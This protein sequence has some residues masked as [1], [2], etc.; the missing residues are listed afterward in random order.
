MW[1]AMLGMR[2][3][4][5]EDDHRVA[6]MLGRLLSKEGFVVDRART[7]TDAVRKALRHTY[8]CIVL[9]LMLPEMDGLEVCR[10]VRSA[11]CTS[12]I[13][14]LTA[15]TALADRVA[16]LDEGAD[17][18]LG[19]P[20]APT[21]LLARLR[22][23]LRRVPDDH[24]PVVQLGEFVLDREARTVELGGEV[25]ELRPREVELMWFFMNHPG[26]AFGRAEILSEVWGYDYS[27]NVVDVYVAYLREKIDR[28]FGVDVIQTVRGVGYRFSPPSNVRTV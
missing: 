15:R 21:E 9:D 14:M 10:E 28:R 19:K 23:L 11:G 24:A 4:V 22:A 20:F 3:L 5:V 26:R 17:D 1:S 6:S 18:Y 13:L 16:G 7:G 2:C 8:S 12:P 27:S 25:V